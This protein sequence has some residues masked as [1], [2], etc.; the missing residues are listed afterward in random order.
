MTFDICSS[1]FWN[2]TDTSWKYPT[3][4]FVHRSI[5]TGKNIYRS[6][7]IQVNLTS[8]QILDHKGDRISFSSIFVCKTHRATVSLLT[9]NLLHQKCK[10]RTLAESLSH[11]KIPSTHV[12]ISLSYVKISLPHE[13]ASLHHGEISHIIILCKV[14]IN[15]CKSIIITYKRYFYLMSERIVLCIIL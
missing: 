13:E 6:V 1:R 11:V 15:S 2:K 3:K 9:V 12:K 5:C 14:S 10:K 4:I 7:I 8:P